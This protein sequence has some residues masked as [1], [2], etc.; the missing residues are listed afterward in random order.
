MRVLVFL[1]CLVSACASNAG[2]PISYGGGSAG[3][4]AESGVA[5]VEANPSGLAAYALRLEDV[6]PVAPAERPRTHRV[7]DGEA[8]QDIAT[9]YQI[10]MLALIEHNGLEPPYAI[11]PGNEVRLP[12][13][14]IYIVARDDTLVGIADRFGVD[15]R[16]LALFNRRSPTAPLAPGERIALPEL[17]RA[18]SPSEVS[19]EPEPIVRGNARFAMP[20]RGRVVGRFGGQSDGSRLDGIEISGAEG[21]AVR[22]AAD[23]IVVYAGEDVPGYGTLVLIRHNDNYVTAYGFNRRALVREGESVRVGAPVAELGAR[24]NGRARLLFQVR[25]GS[26]AIDPQPLLGL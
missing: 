15:A 3:L 26:R 1:V 16:S 8:L 19:P 2:A 13:A 4:P 6:H 9:R 11:T 7:R 10:P 14:R 23:G 17:A 25:Q 12:R 20:L 22:A 24:P 5:R 18:P 21:D